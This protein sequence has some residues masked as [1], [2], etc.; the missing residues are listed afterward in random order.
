MFRSM[1]S[2]VGDPARALAVA[3]LYLVVGNASSAVSPEE[4]ERLKNDLT[5]LG[6]ER[7]G[8]AEGSIPAWEGGYRKQLPDWQ[9]GQPRPSPF[10]DE[11]PRFTVTAQNMEQ[12]AD[13]LSEGL[14]GLLK[15]Y[16]DYRIPVYPT[17][18]TGHAPQ[19]VY[20]N[21]L[22]NATRASLIEDGTGVEGAYGGIPF[23]VPE[24]GREVL[25]NHRLAW[26]GGHAVRF[27]TESWLVTAGG[28]RTLATAG[29]EDELYEYYDPEGSLE[30]YSG[31][32]SR[33]KL[34][35]TSP[36]SKRGEALIVGQ[37]TD[38]RGVEGW[39]YLVGQRRVRR[40]PTPAYDTP[41]FVNSGV[42]FFD[43]AFMLFGPIDKHKLKLLGKRELI[44]PYNTNRALSE[45]DPERLVGSDFFD[46]E[47]MRWEVHRVWVVEATRKS[48]ERHVVERRK[49]YVDED[50]WQI[51]LADGWDAKGELWRMQFA[52]GLLAPDMEGHFANINWGVLDLR[53]GAYLIT[54]SQI[55]SDS[56]R[57]Q[58]IE[59]PD[60]YDWSPDSLADGLR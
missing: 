58:R 21:T 19:W 22:A 29:V 54:A 51:V 55:S 35:N 34:V 49:Y 18:R 27:T 17:H 39:Q 32:G 13:R 41:D 8:N 7:A 52:L 15:K 36:A 44:V 38:G 43:E 57:Y 60:P 45:G 31:Y 37:P 56:Q 30:A 20:D 24:N 48:D 40:T 33:Q 42:N 16:P 50:T 6:A 25:W 26:R 28:R 11:E 14:K 46:P 23:P 12:H 1:I 53:T 5:P 59:D 4:A 47:L 3:M 10:A 2:R 9:P